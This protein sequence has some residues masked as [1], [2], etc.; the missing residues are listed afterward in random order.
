MLYRFDVSLPPFSRFSL[1]ERAVITL[2]RD[3]VYARALLLLPLIAVYYVIAAMIY[4]HAAAA[5]A[6]Y[7]AAR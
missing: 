4:G 1:Y 3:Y 5:R 2:L 7:D 6:I